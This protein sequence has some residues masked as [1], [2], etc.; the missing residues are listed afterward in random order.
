MAER[1]SRE[2]V[3]GDGARP[4]VLIGGGVRSGKSRFALARA[5]R[6]GPRRVFVATA[7]PLDAEM[8]ARIRRHQEE[9]SG[10]GFQTVEEPVDLAATLEASYAA[11]DVIVVDC[12]TLWVSNLLVRGA[13]AAEVTPAFDGLLAALSRRPVPVI[14][15]SNEVGMGLVPETPLGRL[16]RDQ[17]GMLHQ[18]LAAVADELYAGLMGALVRLKPGPMSL[19]S[20]GDGGDA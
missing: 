11:A 2:R 5:A 7:E 12:L 1:P 15:V 3:P 4:L 10:A 8:A 19:V 14:L 13:G 17:T 16:F 18:R 20:A 6:T 9:R